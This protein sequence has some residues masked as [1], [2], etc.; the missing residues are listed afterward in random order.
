[1]TLQ[2]MDAAMDAGADDVQPATGEDDEVAGF[3]VG[4][5]C[6]SQLLQ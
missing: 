6:R 3:K 2:V 1:M 4:S 5:A